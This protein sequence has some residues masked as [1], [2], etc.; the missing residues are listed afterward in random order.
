M[1]MITFGGVRKHVHKSLRNAENSQLMVYGRR[2]YF[3]SMYCYCSS[4]ERMHALRQGIASGLFG[5][6]GITLHIQSEGG[7]FV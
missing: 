7:K 4:E 5:Q 1:A 3:S 2:I 6:H